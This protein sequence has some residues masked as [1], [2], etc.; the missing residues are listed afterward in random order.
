MKDV[1]L[2][3]QRTRILQMIKSIEYSSRTFDPPLNWSISCSLTCGKACGNPLNVLYDTESCVFV[4]FWAV[5]KGHLLWICHQSLVISH[6]SRNALYFRETDFL[7]ALR[8]LGNLQAK[9][10]GS[11]KALTYIV[12]STIILATKN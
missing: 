2:I 10:K 1:L 6:S 4:F 5:K 7:S 9:I 11:T 8:Y 3:F 12:L